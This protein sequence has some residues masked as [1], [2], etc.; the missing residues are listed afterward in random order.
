MQLL[1]LILRKSLDACVVLWYNLDNT[2]NLYIRR[3]I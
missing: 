3:H 1:L 2:P